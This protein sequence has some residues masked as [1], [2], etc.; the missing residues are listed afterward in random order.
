[1]DEKL[2]FLAVWPH[3]ALSED[4]MK[5]SVLEDLTGISVVCLMT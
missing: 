1:M 3:Y 4:M 5:R 2:G